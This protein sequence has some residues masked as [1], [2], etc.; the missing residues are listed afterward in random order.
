[1]TKVQKLSEDVKKNKEMMMPNRGVNARGKSYV[2][3]QTGHYYCIKYIL[4]N[5]YIHIY[6]T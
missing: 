2:F 3:S 6:I 1:M 5:K 4:K